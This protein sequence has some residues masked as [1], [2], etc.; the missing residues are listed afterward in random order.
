MTRAVI[1]AGGLLCGIILIYSVAPIS[2]GPKLNKFSAYANAGADTLEPHSWYDAAMKRIPSSSWL[3]G[4]KDRIP[5]EPIMAMM[6]NATLKAELGRATWKF[7]HTMAGKYPYEPKPEDREALLDFMYSFGKIY[8]CGDCAQHFRKILIA[9]PPDVTN[10]TTF[11][12]WMCKVH[13][14]VNDRLRKPA[15]DCSKVGDQYMCGCAD[16]EAPK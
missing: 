16:D 5:G 14:I 1:L 11:S 4:A 15:Y 7:L 6:G 8:P 3:G 2:D 12:Q 13:N 9:N 10:R